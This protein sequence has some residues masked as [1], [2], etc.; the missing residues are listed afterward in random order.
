MSS[1]FDIDTY[2]A[3]GLIGIVI[4]AFLISRMGILPKKSLPF[5]VGG[6]V[7]VS[8]LIIFRKWRTNGLLKDLKKREE[9]LKKMEERLKLLKEQYGASEQ[10][11]EKARAELDDQ[12]A[13]YEKNIILI[14]AKNKQERERINALE[15]EELHGEFL[16]VVN[17]L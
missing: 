16:D 13:A 8:G 11:L 14:Q 9:E 7:G 4:V 17:N 12:R 15:G 5:I 10:E 6:L 2:I 1:F 3:F